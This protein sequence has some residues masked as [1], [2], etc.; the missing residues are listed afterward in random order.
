MK[1][2]QEIKEKIN[3]LLKDMIFYHDAYTDYR[4]GYLDA[5]W[6]LCSFFNI[7]CQRTDSGFSILGDNYILEVNND[8][9]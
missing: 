2:E 7:K 6:H 5:C 3:E 1:T 8:N 9:K 4:K